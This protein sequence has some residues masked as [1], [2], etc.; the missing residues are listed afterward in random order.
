MH[1]NRRSET[2]DKL[3][4]VMQG[5]NGNG[6]VASFIGLEP[7]KALFV[8]LYSIAGSKPLS[9]RQFWRVPAYIEMKSFGHKGW[10]HEEKKKVVLWFDLVP[11]DFYA[12]WKG[13]MVVAWSPPER[14][15]WRRAHRNDFPVLSVSEDSMLDAVMPEW[16]A[17]DLTWE[18]LSVLPTRWKSA[19]SQWRGIY[20]IFDGSDC[21]GYVGAAYGHDNI[22]GRWLGYA[23]R[24]HGGNRLLRQRDPHSFRFTILQRVSPDMETGDVIRLETSWKV[25]LHTRDPLGLNDN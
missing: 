21:K 1:I 10:T 8:G 23:K 9:Y 19:L 5:L 24:G 6:H 12:Q 2:K 18:E 22:L 11:T 3:E 15:W 20:Y 4:P 13:K 16:N 17:I 14:S 25:R 7:G